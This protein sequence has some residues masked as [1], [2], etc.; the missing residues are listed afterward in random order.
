MPLT[1]GDAASNKVLSENRARSIARAFL[2]G[3][4]GI[5]IS[6]AGFGEEQLLVPTP[7]E[8]PE[9]RNRR[10]TYIVA[11]TPPTGV[12]WTRLGP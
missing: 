8:T 5:P 6:Y 9:P 7:D 2:A 10:A 3:G 11:I 12:R 4:A 1:V